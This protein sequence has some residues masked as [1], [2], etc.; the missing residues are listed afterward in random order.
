VKNGLTDGQTDAR[1]QSDCLMP[2]APISR[3][4]IKHPKQIS[5]IT[6]SLSTDS[7]Q[8]IHTV[9]LAVV[10]YHDS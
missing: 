8:W 7:V 10:A 1:G 9:V 6:V 2:P 3:E 5:S 4:G